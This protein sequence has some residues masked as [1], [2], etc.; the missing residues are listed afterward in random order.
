[1]RNTL[2]VELDAQ[3]HTGRALQGLDDLA[4]AKVALGVEAAS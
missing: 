3:T 1:M 4:L 2:I